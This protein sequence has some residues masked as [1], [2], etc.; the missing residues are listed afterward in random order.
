MDVQ[1]NITLVIIVI[2]SKKNCGKNITSQNIV[3]SRKKKHGYCFM[4]IRVDLC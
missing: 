2:V 3:I 4:Q 1:I